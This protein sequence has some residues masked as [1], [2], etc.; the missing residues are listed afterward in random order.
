MAKEDW[1]DAVGSLN[2]SQVRRDASRAF[3]PP[4]GGT[5]SVHYFNS[6]VNTPGVVAKYHNGAGFSPTNA[7][8]GLKISAA[9]KRG[10]SGGATGFAPL[11]FSLLQGT[12][13]G[14]IA[15]VVGLGDA[16]P[17]HIILAKVPLTSGLPDIAPGTQGVWKRSVAT[18]DPDTW[19]HLQLDVVVNSSGGIANDTVVTVKMSDL[20]VN[21]VTTP[22]F[23]AIPGMDPLYDDAGGITTG[24]PGLTTGRGGFGMQSAD[25]TRRVYFDHI[26]LTAQ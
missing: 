16:N 26:R 23:V 22:N 3:T 14:D 9:L 21:P 13:V 11:L 5:L 8:Q 4:N 18:F 20:G 17:A 1:T 10:V 15:Y 6:V 24:T 2:T 19:V 25:S 12:G 7:L